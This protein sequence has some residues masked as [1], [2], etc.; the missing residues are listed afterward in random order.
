MAK[1]V[2]EAVMDK[3]L[4]RLVANAARRQNQGSCCSQKRF[5]PEIS[6]GRS[7]IFRYFP[8]L[9]MYFIL[10]L[11]RTDFMSKRDRQQEC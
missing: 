8:L 11:A 1:S 5:D 7:G 10:I 3:T 2:S 9:Q 4:V 6:M